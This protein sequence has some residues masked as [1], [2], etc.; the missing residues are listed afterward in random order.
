MA[1]VVVY[2]GIFAVA[3]NTLYS[4]G[5]NHPSVIVPS[6]EASP[7]FQPVKLKILLLLL[8]TSTNSTSGNP[9]RGVGSGKNSLMITSPGITESAT[10]Y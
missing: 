9:I 5:S 6:E 3:V 10:R 8:Y 1:D 7:I 4:P 2:N